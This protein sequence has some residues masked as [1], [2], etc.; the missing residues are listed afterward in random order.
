ML[1]MVS[2]PET[3]V[4]DSFL[5]DTNQHMNSD[6]TW[7]QNVLLKLW[8]KRKQSSPVIEIHFISEAKSLIS[9]FTRCVL[10]I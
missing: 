1:V 9:R 4:S 6:I 7:L 10:I 5:K 3:S 8:F 2:N